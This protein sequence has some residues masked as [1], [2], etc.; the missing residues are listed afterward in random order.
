VN[1]VLTRLASEVYGATNRYLPRWEVVNAA[2][3][4]KHSHLYE[5]WIPLG[6]QELPPEAPK[7]G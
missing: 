6:D 2:Y 3:Y 7:V 1:C 4:R 5:G